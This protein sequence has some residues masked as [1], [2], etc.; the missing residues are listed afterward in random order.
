MKKI[1]NNNTN[2]TEITKYRTFMEFDEAFDIF[3]YDLDERWR[4]QLIFSLYKAATNPKIET[5]MDFC[6]EYKI[7]RQRI[8]ELAERYPRVKTAFNDFRHILANKDLKG[9]KHRQYDKDVVMKYIH[10]LDPEWESINK[11]HADLKNTEASTGDKIFIEIPHTTVETKADTEN[12]PSVTIIGD[13]YN[14]ETGSNQS[15]TL[16][17]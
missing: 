2:T 12:K 8:Y 16:T 3:K 1:P 5:I 15:G 10:K 9:A 14:D 7:R 17:E 6:I 11:Y 13:E 4:E